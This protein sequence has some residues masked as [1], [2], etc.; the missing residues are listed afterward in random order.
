MLKSVCLSF[1]TNVMKLK[2]LTVKF[3]AKK[4]TFKKNVCPLLVFTGPG[5]SEFFETRTSQPTLK[6]KPAVEIFVTQ[7]GQVRGRING[8]RGRQII[9]SR[10]PRARPK[11]KS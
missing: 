2:K 7:E 6:H 3:S 11:I 5:F 10:I 1:F 4:M 9:I 8:I